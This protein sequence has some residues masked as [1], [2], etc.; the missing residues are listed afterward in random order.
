MIIK[1]KIFENNTKDIEIDDYVLLNIKGQYI[2]Y[3]DFI[4]NNIGVVVSKN[5]YRDLIEVRYV[6]D[7]DDFIKYKK[8]FRY[9]ST[10]NDY[11]S[12]MFFYSDVVEIGKTPDE[13]ILKTNTKKF[14]L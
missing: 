12:N 10:D 1:F 2:D 9:L 13:V 8:Y 3:N 7:P 4:N 14:N 6:V 5:D 11:F